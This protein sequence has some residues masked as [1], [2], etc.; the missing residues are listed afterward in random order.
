MEKFQQIRINNLNFTENNQYFTFKIDLGSEK[1]DL[2]S[3]MRF[4]SNQL[5]F[6]GTAPSPSNG[7][8]DYTIQI[9]CIN[10]CGKSA[11]ET[12]TIH[13]EEDPDLS[14]VDSAIELKKQI[15][16]QIAV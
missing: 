10:D 16:I 1:A 7:N 2:P 15:Q 4:Y 8:I 3:W 14:C 13:L 12:F 9:E 5:L 11:S 6:E